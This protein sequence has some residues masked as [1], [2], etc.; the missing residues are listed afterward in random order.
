MTGN[1]RIVGLT[2]LPA[3]LKLLHHGDGTVTGTNLTF[4]AR[5]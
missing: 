4:V 1:T 2:P 3:K 5:R